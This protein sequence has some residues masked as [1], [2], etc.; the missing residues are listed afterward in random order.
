MVELTPEGSRRTVSFHNNNRWACECKTQWHT[1]TH[2]RTLSSSL[3]SAALT[4]CQSVKKLAVY[5]GLRRP[6]T[7]HLGGL[8]VQ[9]SLHPPTCYVLHS[10][11]LVFAFLSEGF[12][13]SCWAR[14]LPSP[15][16]AIGQKG[17][18]YLNSYRDGLHTSMG[19]GG[20]DGEMNQM[21]LNGGKTGQ[22]VK[23]HHRLKC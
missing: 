10:E 21:T 16:G 14:S 20:A 18:T 9:Y 7:M 6:P 13:S 23:K 17:Y 2:P 1:H 12:M 22:R 5:S 19:E 3:A 8:I 4:D 15:W 11:A